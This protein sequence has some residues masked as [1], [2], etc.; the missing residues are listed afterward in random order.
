MPCRI[1]VH[2]PES[3]VIVPN[4]G[5]NPSAQKEGWQLTASVHLTHPVKCQGAYMACAQ[6]VSTGI[7]MA[8]AYGHTCASTYVCSCTQT[9]TCITDTHTRARRKLDKWSI[10]LALV[11]R[12]LDLAFSTCP[13]QS[14][15]Q[16]GLNRKHAYLSPDS[17]PQHSQPLCLES[18]QVRVP[19]MTW[20]VSRKP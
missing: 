19:A 14:A 9:H 5:P 8:G 13:E 20:L 10:R 18:Q 12:Q 3:Q 15:A 2:V 1:H 16:P 6:A 17:S 7:L 11:S 4:N